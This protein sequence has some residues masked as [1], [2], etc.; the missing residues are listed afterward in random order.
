MKDFIIEFLVTIL[1][2]IFGLI[3]AKQA[4]KGLA[5]IGVRI[6]SNDPLIMPT[7]KALASIAAGIPSPVP[8]VA[9]QNTT[10]AMND[11]G[12]N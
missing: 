8:A 1:A 7:S 5:K 11:A 9:A 10:S 4:A 3:I 12:G 6:S 2:V